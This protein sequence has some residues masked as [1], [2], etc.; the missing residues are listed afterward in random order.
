M[1]D[2]EF[3][4]LLGTPDGA[5]TLVANALGSP[6]YM[7]PEQAGGWLTEISRATDV[8]GLGAVLCELLS[9]RPPFAGAS[10]VETMRR[11]A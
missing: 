5:V 6:S 7:A 11:A 4:K 3:A 10:P 9:G 8:Y 1:T 2:F